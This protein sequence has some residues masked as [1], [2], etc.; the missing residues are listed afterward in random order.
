MSLRTSDFFSRTLSA[1]KAVTDIVA[2]RIFLPARPTIDE[3]EDK[4]PYVIIEPGVLQN[5][6]QTKDSSVEGE[7]DSVTVSILCVAESH[8]KLTDLCEAVREECISAWEAG[9]DE[10]VPVE[11][12]F[13]AS[14][15]NYDPVKPCN[16]MR[17]NYQCITNR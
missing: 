15:E 11:W 3:D 5:I 6:S 4:I 16:Y 13:S 17:L 14:E 2:D 9:T 7:E 8:D 10:D 1:S 12:T